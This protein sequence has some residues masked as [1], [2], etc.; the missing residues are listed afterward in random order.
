MHEISVKETFKKE[1]MKR[2]EQI[3]ELEIEIFEKYIPWMDL[4]K[5]T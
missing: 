1:T 5:Y 2:I 3:L 4:V